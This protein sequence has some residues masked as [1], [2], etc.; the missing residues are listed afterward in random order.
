MI[1]VESQS[2]KPNPR[3]RPVF[4][5]RQHRLVHTS[6]TIRQMKNP[7]LTRHVQH[8]LSRAFEA[9]AATDDNKNVLD[10]SHLPQHIQ[11]LIPNGQKYITKHRLSHIILKAEKRGESGA[12][13][14][15]NNNSRKHLRFVATEYL[16]DTDG[17]Y[18][19]NISSSHFD[20]DLDVDD[21]DSNGQPSHAHEDVLE[22]L[23]EMGFDQNLALFAAN[24]FHTIEGALAMLTSQN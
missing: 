6:H 13:Q 8:S 12:T 11:A 19:D 7:E 2:S 1:V 20:T 14:H 9:A 10:A 17:T 3:P 21:D 18:D 22:Q 15:N 5:R 16:R 24:E 4:D 23:L